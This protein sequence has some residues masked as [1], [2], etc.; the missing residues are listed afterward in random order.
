MTRAAPLH[1]RRDRAVA[2]DAGQNLLRT[3]L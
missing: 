1:S 3:D 2:L